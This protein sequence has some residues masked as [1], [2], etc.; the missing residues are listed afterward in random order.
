MALVI[1]LSI[2]TLSILVAAYILSDGVQINDF[3]TALVVAIV[4]GVLN[5]FVKPIITLLTLPITMLTFGLFM[6]VINA[7]LVML[8]GFVIPG[9]EVVNFWWALLFSLIVSLISSFMNALLKNT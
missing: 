9:F 1:R 8:A 5:M 6:F 7:L 2:T 4:L 3:W